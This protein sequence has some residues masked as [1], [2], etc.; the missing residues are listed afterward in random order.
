LNK[1][2]KI[3]PVVML[4]LIAAPFL[5]FVC[6][7]VQQKVQQHRMLEKLEHVSL[8]SISINKADIIWVKNS[9]EVLIG[10]ELFDV[11]SYSF[12]N[13]KIILTGLFDKDE[14]AL[15]K[16]YANKL[17]PNNK[18]SIPTD[19]LVLK[20]MFFCAIN[21]HNTIN[22]NFVFDINFNTNYF[23][24]SQKSITQYLSIHTPPPNT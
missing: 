7:V 2:K 4:T 12:V 15:K 21:N 10:G 1:L 9:K 19:E 23:I 14:D 8:Q 20:C 3:L 11:K 5:F 17:Y 13:D 6:F 16:N 22:E 18:K 24:F